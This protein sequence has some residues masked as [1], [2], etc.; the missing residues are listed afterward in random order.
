MGE[1]KTRKREMWGDGGN[2]YETLRLQ[3]ILCASQYTLPER[4]NFRPDLQCH[5]SN[6][7]SSEPK[8][9]SCTPDFSSLL[10]AYT[11]LSSS[12]PISLCL[13]HNSTIIAENNVK[14]SLSISPWSWVDTKYSIQQVQ[15][16]PSTAYTE[17]SIYRVSH[18]HMIVQLPCSLI[19]TSWP[20]DA[21]LASIVP[22]Y[23][24]DPHMPALHHSFKCKFTWSYCYCCEVTN[25]WIEY[26][27][28]AHH[29]ATAS[30]SYQILLDHSF[31]VYLQ[32]CSIMCVQLCTILASI[33][34]L[35][36]SRLQHASAYLQPP[37]TM[38]CKYISWLTWSRSGS[39]SV[40]S[41]NHHFPAH[42][43]LLWC[44]AYCQSR[45]TVCRW[46]A[47]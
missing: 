15:H 13:V 5:T 22:S 11:S 21:A 8:Y 6:A 3:R 9:R 41:L 33:I 38:A 32:T 1:L 26:Q 18:P 47:I 29:P 24:I 4:D 43:E 40:S 35:K 37:S 10:V 20:L 12:S 19:V 27:Q 17:Y 14:L 2:Q 31:N 23:T 28:L 16:T 7:R 25:S 39:L 44:T 36:L 42:L 34:K 45:Y 30:S 46:V